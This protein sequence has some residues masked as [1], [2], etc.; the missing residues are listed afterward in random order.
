MKIQSSAV[1]MNSNR[2][3]TEVTNEVVTSSIYVERPSAKKEIDSENKTTGKTEKEGKDKVDVSEKG[4]NFADRQKNPMIK[5]SIVNTGMIYSA[6]SISASSYTTSGSSDIK[7]LDMMLQALGFKKSSVKTFSLDDMMKSSQQSSMS[8]QSSQMSMYS[9]A[10]C[11]QLGNSNSNATGGTGQWVREVHVSAFHAETENTS[12]STTGIVKTADGREINFNL[13]MEMSRSFSQ[14]VN[15][16]WKE[17]LTFE[18]KDP[19]VINLTAGEATF[20]DKKFLFDIDADGTKENISQLNSGSGYLA[21]D[22]NGDG[23]INDGSELFGAKTGDG[24]GE[25]SKYDEDGN[26]WI[27]ENDSVFH[28]LKVWTKDENGK[29][30]LVALGKVGIGAIYLQSAPTD[31]TQKSM[32]TGDVNAQIRK[33]GVY[34]KENGEVGTIQHVDV[35]G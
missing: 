31:F 3:Y 22:K 7:L 25:L 17:Q 13:D 4:K 16:N 8:F 15:A 12:F 9:F 34:L 20:S 10:G 26:G 21:L 11:F 18:M 2:T 19:L 6:S 27:D 5:G 23:K 24:F 29:D 30:K 1:E 28:K 14:F 33:T 32:Q 35:A